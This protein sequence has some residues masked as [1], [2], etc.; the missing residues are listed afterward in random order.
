MKSWN[1]ASSLLLKYTS[2]GLAAQEYGFSLSLSAA[3]VAARSFLC[4]S[5]SFLFGPNVEPDDVALLVPAN[6]RQSWV[7]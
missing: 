2:E 3:Q 5:K 1:T 6:I 7:N 4:A